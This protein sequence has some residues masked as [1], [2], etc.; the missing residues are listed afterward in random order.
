MTMERCEEVRS[1]CME[2]QIDSLTE[3]IPR[4]KGKEQIQ[5]YTQPSARHRLI[6]P[7]KENFDIC[8]RTMTLTANAENKK[9]ICETPGSL[10]APIS[11][12]VDLSFVDFNCV[13][14]LVRLHSSKLETAVGYK[15]L[16]VPFLTPIIF[17]QGRRFERQIDATSLV[18]STKSRKL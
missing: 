5:R 16:S 15:R 9:A 7:S 2:F 12:L 14:A 13:P 1:C 11:L 17:L 18:K 10:T 3:P 6:L 8:K 4:F